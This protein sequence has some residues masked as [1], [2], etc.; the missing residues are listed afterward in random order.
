MKRTIQFIK[1]VL[2]VVAVLA[3]S[4]PAAAQVSTFVTVTNHSEEALTWCGA[5]TGQMVVSGYPAGSCAP[6]QA[7]MWDAIQAAKVEASWDTDPAGLRSAMTTQCPLPPTGH[8]A[9]F[10]DPSAPSVMHSV[11]RWMRSLHY[12]VAAVLNTNPHNTLTTHREHWVVIKGIVTDLDPVTNPSVTLQFVF[13]TDQPANLGDPAVDRF[14][15]GSQWYSEFQAVVNASSAYNGKFVA[16]IEPPQVRGTA[17]AK[18]LP[19]TGVLISSERA[20]A[21]AKNAINSLKYAESFREIGQMQPQTPVLVNPGRR[22]YYIVPFAKPGAAPS[23]AILINAYSGDL[24]E[25]GRFAPRPILAE[26]D[27]ISRVARLLGRETLVN[28]KTTLVSTERDSPY[29][30]AW[31]VNVDGENVDVQQNGATRRAVPEPIAIPRQ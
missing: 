3:L 17:T 20:V 27:A 7:D 14:L 6:I 15:T 1:L 31:R 13:I 12:P 11:A 25:A 23:M 5:A 22:G 24:M 26:R 8:W 4:L 9:I 30:P 10:A 19:I 28:A 16:I 29:F 21:A 18:V 2:G